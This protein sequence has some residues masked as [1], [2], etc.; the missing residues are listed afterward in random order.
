[1]NEQTR[2]PRLL[3]LIAML[4]ALLLLGIGVYLFSNDRANGSA[5]KDRGAE[6]ASEDAAMAAANAGMSAAQRTATEKLIRA[7]I[8]EHPEIITEAV[9]ILQK[10]DALARLKSAGDKITT[11]FP[12]AEAG[13]PDGDVTLVEFTDYNCGYCR[14]SVADVQRLLK[15]DGN[16]RLV[17]REL[18]ILS[19]TSRDAALWALAAAKQGKHKAFHDAMFSGGRPDAQTIRAA[20]NKAGVNLA[21]AEK[22][23]SS[24]EAMAEIKSNLEVMQQ[25]GF[26]GTPTFIVGDQILEGAVGVDALKTA[27]ANARNKG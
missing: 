15:S 4:A 18:P 21:A 14:S 27:V 19:E 2:N 11:V 7:Y 6:I 12:G 22:F 23:V 20:A 1:M 26:N 13:N 5:A 25:I 24:P 8:L 17:Y 16:I 9:D 3:T 10:R